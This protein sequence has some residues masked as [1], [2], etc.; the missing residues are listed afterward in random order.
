MTKMRYCIR[1]QA[2]KPAD[3]FVCLRR[4]KFGR[5]KVYV[6]EDCNQKIKGIDMSVAARDAFGRG[7]TESNHADITAWKKR[8]PK[9]HLNE[10]P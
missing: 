6:C 10:A 3:G 2:D 5:S 9:Q 1:C 8:N 4:G 7:V